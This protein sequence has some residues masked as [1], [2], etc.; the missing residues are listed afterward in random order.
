MSTILRTIHI[1]ITF[2]EYLRVLIAI[3]GRMPYLHMNFAE[4]LGRWVVPLLVFFLLSGLHF[5]PH[6]LWF[7]SLLRF[8]I[9][10]PSDPLQSDQSLLMNIR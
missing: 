5:D 3:L 6:F 7:G 8:L 4:L 2:L 9:Q 1:K 10:H